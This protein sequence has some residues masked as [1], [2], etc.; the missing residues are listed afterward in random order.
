MRIALSRFRNFRNLENAVVRWNPGL[1]VLVGANGAGKTNALEALHVLTGWGAFGGSRLAEVVKWNSEG[2]ALLAA[3][4]EGERSAVVEAA[5]VARA[6]LRLDGKLCRWGDLRSCVQSLAF[7]PSDM[8]LIEGSP[9]V[10]RRFLDV[11]CAL[12]FPLYAYRLGE[13]KKILRTR[14][15]LLSRGHSVR[16]TQETMAGLAV[17]IWECRLRVVEALRQC[18]EK[19]GLLLPRP[20]ELRLKRGGAGTADDLVEDFRRSCA[21]LEARER[22]AGTPLVGPHRDELLL[23]CDERPAAAS[24]S[25]GQRRRTA[26]ALIM[27]AAS[28]V[29]G[30][31][32]SSP[33]L[34][35]DEVTSELDA[36]GRAVLMEC[37]C[38][39]GWQIFAAT[40]EPPL[41]R[42]KGALWRI[43]DGRVEKS[44]ENE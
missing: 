21:A 5:I 33:V 24:L 29:E 35:F 15:Y 9:A 20:V 25:R 18:L 14:R 39:S 41:P 10:R 44:E 40:A 2:G 16:V 22:A 31:Y 36:E 19:W 30:R 27:A 1:N 28:A 12:Y 3:Q 8:A 23:T 4:A 26:L 37:F 11:L 6:S 38:H 34:L 13:Y 32:R 43:S 7:L 17:W 42:F